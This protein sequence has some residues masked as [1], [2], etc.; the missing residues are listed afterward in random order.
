MHYID[1]SSL[2]HA[3]YASRT[4]LPGEEITTT[5]IY[6]PLPP[7][8]NLDCL[9]TRPDINVLQTYEERQAHL[10]AAWGFSCTCALCSSNIGE[11]STS[12]SR[13]R[14]I[15]EMQT[16]LSDWSAGSLAT[17]KM[18]RQL[19]ALYEAEEIHAAIGK[20]H[21]FAALA[22]NAVGDTFRAKK[23]ARL[24]IEV[25]IVNSGGEKDEDVKD[26]LMLKENPEGH[27]SYMAR[28]PKS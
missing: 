1:S 27:W 6:S 2:I 15:L 11:I 14:E 4:I 3:T 5:C 25:G 22:H 9:L 18:S 23:H 13:T 21:V 28:M 10:R 17:P 19:L 24:A 20:G 26:M 16:Y 8:C 12:D 7:I